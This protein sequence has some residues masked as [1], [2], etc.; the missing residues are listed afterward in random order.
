M[1]NMLYKDIVIMYVIY[2]CYIK[3][4]MLNMLHKDINV[5]FQYKDINDF[6]L[7]IFLSFWNQIDFE[8]CPK[9]KGNCRVC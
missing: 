4:L 3:I 9:M 1:L 5:F 6:L 8:F 2:V 7:R